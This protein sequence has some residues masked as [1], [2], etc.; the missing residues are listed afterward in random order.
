M[1]NNN[2]GVRC[3]ALSGRTG[4]ADRNP[5]RCP[6]ALNVFFLG[7]LRFGVGVGIVERYFMVL[8]LQDFLDR[9]VAAAQVRSRLP[10]LGLLSCRGLG[11][12]VIPH[13]GQPLP[14][15]L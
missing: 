5:G 6:Y 10:L 8:A 14:Q 4:W 3:C 7:L 12:A 2:M 13:P 9:T 15:V 11:P 1:R